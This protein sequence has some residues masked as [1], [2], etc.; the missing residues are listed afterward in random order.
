MPRNAQNPAEDLRR[1]E[2]ELDRYGWTSIHANPST[3]YVFRFRL[4]GKELVCKTVV[5][6]LTFRAEISQ[7]APDGDPYVLPKSLLEQVAIA[8][9]DA[10]APAGFSC[11]VGQGA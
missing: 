1:H 3:S 6:E 9:E 4:D 5:D 8:A 2:Q 10:H 11:A 7:S